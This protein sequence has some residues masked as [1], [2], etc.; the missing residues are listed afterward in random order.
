MKIFLGFVGGLVLGTILA[1]VGGFDF[2]ERGIF[3]LFIVVMILYI[4]FCGAVIGNL[5]EN[6]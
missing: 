3:T 6:S 4:G 1:W 5:F 2:N